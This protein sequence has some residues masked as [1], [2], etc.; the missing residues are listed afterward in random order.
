MTEP[1][2]GA[3]QVYGGPLDGAWVEVTDENK[4]G[5]DYIVTARHQYVYQPQVHKKTKA[6][7]VNIPRCFYYAG[8][9]DAK[10]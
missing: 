3:I 5:F 4:E 7:I 10:R 2:P 8:A 6:A 9:T 1:K